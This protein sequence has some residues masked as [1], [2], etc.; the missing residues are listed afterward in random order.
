MDVA[1]DCGFNS[2]E[3]FTK[4]F[5]EAFG[6]TPDQ[7]RKNPV[8]LVQF[9]KPALVTDAIYK[10]W[11]YSEIWLEQHGLVLDK[12]AVSPEVYY[13]NKKDICY[14]ELWLATTEKLEELQ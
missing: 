6:I 1:L 8:P 5:K 13:P 4:T 10:A 7:Y 9:S 11:N 12:K 2:H 3:F 14:M